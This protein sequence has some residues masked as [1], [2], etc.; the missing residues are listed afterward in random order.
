LADV[1]G[2][3]PIKKVP[4]IVSQLTVLPLSSALPAG[5][6]ATRSNAAPI[7]PQLVV[8]MV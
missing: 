8:F 3:A 6:S 1:P 4:M 5:E 2:I 7:A